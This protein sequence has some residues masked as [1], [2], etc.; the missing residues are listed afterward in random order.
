M[1]A[2]LL[3]FKINIINNYPVVMIVLDTQG[4]S[5]SIAS[6]LHPAIKNSERKN[7]YFKYLTSPVSYKKTISNRFFP[8][9]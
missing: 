8:L 5:V 3:N 7:T 1:Y 2:P 9:T 4:A 6:N